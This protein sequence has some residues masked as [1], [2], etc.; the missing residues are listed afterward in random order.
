MITSRQQTVLAAVATYN[1]RGINPTLKQ[2][3]NDLGYKTLSGVQ[4]HIEPL[5]HK[6]MVADNKGKHGLVVIS[7]ID[8]EMEAELDSIK[9]D[10]KWLSD[11]RIHNQHGDDVAEAVIEQLVWYVIGKEQL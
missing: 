6:G 5:R 3:A 1:R 10:L 4:R 9:K 2:I 11:L 8:P 7:E